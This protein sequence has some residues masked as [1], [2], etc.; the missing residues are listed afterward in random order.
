MNK[1]VVFQKP[2]F[3]GFHKEFTSTQKD[4]IQWNFNMCISSIKI[5]GQPWLV[6]LEANCVGDCCVYEEGEHSNIEWAMFIQSLELI[7]EDLSEPKMTLHFNLN[8]TSS[9]TSESNL[10]YGYFNEQALGCQV[11]RGVWVLYDEVDLIE[12]DYI[13]VRPGQKLVNLADEEFSEKVSYVRPLKPGKAK[14]TTKVLWDE[15]VKGDE[16][17]EAVQTMTGENNSNEE[18]EFVVTSGTTVETSMAYSFNFSNSVSVEVGLS[19][20]IPLIAEI[21]SSVSSTF[22][23]DTGRSESSKV[24]TTIEVEVPA[25]VPP[26]SRLLVNVLRK[27]FTARVPVEIIV[28]RNNVKSITTGELVC[29]SGRTIFA[30]Y[31]TEDL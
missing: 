11:H 25:T 18:T 4:L 6:Y 15:L 26:M 14:V 2:N 16:V 29:H 8:I 31:D 21:S 17:V 12:S 30:E 27:K 5:T 13:V 20:S 9:F 7:T 19:G 28:E 24:T 3:Q 22:S 10:S 1:I 23:F